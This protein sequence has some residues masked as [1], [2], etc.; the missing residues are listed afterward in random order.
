MRSP[1]PIKDE[2]F[3]HLN[4]NKNK[5]NYF[6]YLEYHKSKQTSEQL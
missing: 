3:S 4:K 1:N 5:M 6:L 2:G